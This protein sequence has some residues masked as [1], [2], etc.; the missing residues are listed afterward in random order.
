MTREAFSPSP[1]YPIDGVGPYQITHPY[2]E[3]TL[4]VAAVLNGNRVELLE[5]EY[6][7]SPAES[8]STGEITL[9]NQAAT[10]YDT[11][12]LYIRRATDVE[13]GWLGQSAREK[14]LEAQLDWLAE[15]VQD[16]TSAGKRTV[17]LDGE[18]SPVTPEDG[19]V[20][21]WEAGAFRSGPSETDI[22]DA[23]PNAAIAQENAAI[24][25]EAASK[26][27][28]FSDNLVS[29]V[30]LPSLISPLDAAANR[31]L[32]EGL[33]A[34]GAE[35]DLFG[36]NVLVDY[37]PSGRYRSGSFE[38]E[39]TGISYPQPGLI[40]MSSEG[41]PKGGS[42]IQTQFQGNGHYDPRGRSL[43]I[44]VASGYLE[45]DLNLVQYRS[46]DRGKTWYPKVEET[47]DDI[48][49]HSY[50]PTASW[51][52]GGRT[53]FIGQGRAPEG[54]KVQWFS[55]IQPFVEAQAEVTVS[56]VAGS[57]RV[58]VGFR[59]HGVPSLDWALDPVTMNV[60]K[61][62][63]P[64]GAS[65][66]VGGIPVADILGSR[67][68]SYDGSHNLC[69]ITA[70]SNAASTETSTRIVTLQM[71]TSGFE[72][73]LFDGGTLSLE[74]ALI[75][76]ISGLTSV[77]IIQG[78]THDERLPIAAVSGNIKC[79]VELPTG[80]SK[81]Q[82]L[83][84]KLEFLRTSGDAG[85]VLT[86]PS[87]ASNPYDTDFL[88]GFLRTQ[89]SDTELPN[90]WW[91]ED[92]GATLG[93]Q[94]PIVVPAGYDITFLNRSPIPCALGEDGYI[95]A[96]ATDRLSTGTGVQ[97]M[98]GVYLLMAKL[99]D[100]KLLGGAAF[101][102]HK[103]AET[104]ITARA[105]NEASGISSEAS[106]TGRPTVI[107]EGG[108]LHFFYES[109]RPLDGDFYTSSDVAEVDAVRVTIDTEHRTLTGGQIGGAATLQA[110]KFSDAAGVSA[111]EA[112]A[113]AASIATQ[114]VQSVAALAASVKTEGVAFLADGDRSGDFAWLTGGFS[115]EIANDPAQGVYVASD[116]D[117]TGAWVRMYDGPLQAGW[118]GVERGVKVAQDEAIK[119]ATNFA[120]AYNPDLEFQP[121]LYF[122]NKWMLKRG[123]RYRGLGHVNNLRTGATNSEFDPLILSESAAVFVA[124]GDDWIAEAVDF[125][126]PMYHVGFD[127]TLTNAVGDRH[128]TSLN[129]ITVA[130]MFDGTNGDAVGATA[131]TLR[132]LKVAVSV[133]D[134]FERLSMRNIK[135]IPSCP[136]VA[137]SYG[138]LGYTDYATVRPWA[139]YDIGFFTTNSWGLD[140]QDCQIAGYWG[141]AG[142]FDFL[143]PDDGFTAVTANSEQGQIIN[144][145]I[146]SGALFRSGDLFPIV[147]MTATE[148]YVRWSKSHRFPANGTINISNGDTFV[149]GTD[150]AYTAL[151]YSTAATPSG[152]TGAFLIFT[153]ADTSGIAASSHIITI[154]GQG[155]S[156]HT[157]LRDCAI[158]G[159][160]HLM[161]VDQASDD[162]PFVMDRYIPAL[163]VSGAPMRAIRLEG[164]TLNTLSPVTA[165]VGAARDLTFMGNTY[166]EAKSWRW[167]AGDSLQSARGGVFICGPSA[168]D[169]GDGVGMYADEAGSALK[170]SI[171]FDQALQLN[172]TVSLAPLV[173]PRS[174]VRLSTM[175]DVFHPVEGN[176]RP[177]TAGTGTLDWRADGLADR[178]MYMALR[179]GA[180]DLHTILRGWFASGD[181]LL[182]LGDNGSG[183][184]LLRL[185]SNGAITFYGD[186]D[187]QGALRVNGSI[188]SDGQGGVMFQQVTT[189]QLGDAANAVNTTD[190]R[191]GKM[192]FGTDTN[193]VYYAISSGPTSIWYDL[194]GTSNVTPA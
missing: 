161:A 132:E 56:T 177:Y 19:H 163:E 181:R 36:M 111:A 6:I 24:A 66:G 79:L 81:P 107:K 115:T 143:P 149:G 137:E 93:G 73:M 104:L 190:K 97:A 2:K 189:A 90:F 40:S 192:V 178:Q 9:T 175:T 157:V 121:G 51:W 144:T 160:D 102:I 116:N 150:Y 159:L 134:S 78:I 16:L 71:P 8:L 171:Y 131:A 87:V 114:V 59:N 125:C 48:I 183:S 11:G 92:R 38:I 33:A 85:G 61:F 101:Q 88:F 182:D 52:N 188:V 145:D 179:D 89:N 5:S 173:E 135:I 86:E 12:T 193:K 60:L 44:Q 68:I 54:D 110:K 26:I 99:E 187:F 20:I 123:V 57:N 156:S 21:V 41:L 148:I 154:P 184:P 155:G 106:Q 75:A 172:S 194:E 142:L 174:A 98:G 122:F 34:D 119:D 95:Y 46:T 153:V 129:P 82:T 158:G 139:R 165:H 147:D 176:F 146:Q 7:V 105:G 162:M 133:E 167:D 84:K 96:M 166:A 45:N 76:N 63:I 27:D 127:R 65:S 4:V 170:A 1:S 83:T 118:F 31:L 67:T 126:S 191:E 112:A 28:E 103:V 152:K 22:S 17:R 49:R 180:F 151:A 140:I 108:L 32:L 100:A 47:P 64:D 120:K 91:S 10:D 136:G 169:D 50:Y 117:A 53:N 128:P 39:S 43:E 74:D 55:K 35:I 13:Q 80:V 69:A 14:G 15:A 130:R 138:L 70:A 72:P 29:R 30:D 42:P 23:Q 168:R 58:R 94:S 77:T 141:D 164:C 109:E 113:S 18:T 124:M 186:V 25:Q 37:M 185:R 62:T 3:G